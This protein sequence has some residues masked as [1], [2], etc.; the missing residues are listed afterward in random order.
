M[1]TIE[2]SGERQKAEQI[3]RSL[4]GTLAVQVAMAEGWGGEEKSRR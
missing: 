4:V 1:G 3:L 2:G